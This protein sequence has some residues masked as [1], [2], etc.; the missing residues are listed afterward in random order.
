MA[1]APAIEQ[2]VTALV[3]RLQAIAPSQK[4]GV[5]FRRATEVLATGET[6]GTALFRQFDVDYQGGQDDS[7]EGHGVQSPGVADRRARFQISV[8]YPRAR[9]E[10]KFEDVMASDSEW[11]MRALARS[12]SWAGTPIQR[13]TCR[14]TVDRSRKDK[15]LLVLALEVQYRDTE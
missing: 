4:P 15:L 3:T 12:A 1:Q 5:K 8:Y 9:A 10:K 6:P 14:A 13:T 11:A 2:V 7:Q